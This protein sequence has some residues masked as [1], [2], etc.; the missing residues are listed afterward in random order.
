MDVNAI[1]V[2]DEIPIGATKG[3]HGIAFSPDG[4]LMYI[5]NMNSNDI[6]VI[7]T[8]ADKIVASID[9]GGLE[10]HQIVVREPSIKIGS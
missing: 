6:S 8:S 3:P 7:D 5:S 1:K 9:A 2:I 10:P 4:D